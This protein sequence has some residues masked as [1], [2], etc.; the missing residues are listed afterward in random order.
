MLATRAC[1]NGLAS[2]GAGGR[3]TPIGYGEKPAAGSGRLPG[4]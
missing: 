4:V 3:Y 1:T 2:R